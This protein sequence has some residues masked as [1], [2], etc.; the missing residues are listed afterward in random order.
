MGV[1]ICVSGSVLCHVKLEVYDYM[2]QPA[3]LLIMLSGLTYLTR[4]I[5]SSVSLSFLFIIVSCPIQPPE[6]TRLT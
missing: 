4:H 3:H 1:A 5:S 6:Q 2:G